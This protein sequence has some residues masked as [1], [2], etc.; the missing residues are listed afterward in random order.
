[1]AL[2]G[3]AETVMSDFTAAKVEGKA[4]EGTRMVIVLLMPSSRCWLIAGS[5]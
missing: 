1:M 3:A 4:S 5:I 2:D